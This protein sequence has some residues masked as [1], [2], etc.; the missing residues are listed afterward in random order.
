MHRIVCIMVTILLFSSGAMAEEITKPHTFATGATVKASEFNA[1]FDTVYSKVNELIVLMDAIKNPGSQH[2]DNGDGTVT[3]RLTGLMWMKNADCWGGMT[4]DAA[5]AKVAE[6]NAGTATCTGYT[7]AQ[8]DWRVP[9]IMELKKLHELTWPI[10][11]T[12]HPFTG[13]QTSSY[14]SSTTRAYNTSDAWSVN[15]NSGYVYDNGK[16]NSLY[17]WPVRGGQ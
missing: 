7:G 11:T 2:V 9:N 8:T 16:T 5:I 14:W 17:V 1:N 15:L 3:D 13:V 12:V 6:L 4:W 10:Q